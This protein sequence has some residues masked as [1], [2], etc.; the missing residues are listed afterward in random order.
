MVVD[1]LQTYHVVLDVDQMTKHAVL[2]SC[3]LIDNGILY[4]QFVFMFERKVD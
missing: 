3:T 2:C 1:S 4:L